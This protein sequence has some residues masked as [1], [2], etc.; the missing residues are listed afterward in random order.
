VL[1]V[2]DEAGCTAVDLVGLGA[3][4]PGLRRTLLLPFDDLTPVCASAR[5]RRLRLSRAPGAL[6]LL[7]AGAIPWPA[8]AAVVTAAIDVLPHQLSAAIAFRTGA[9]RRLLVADAPG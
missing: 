4:A 2:E 5:P 7:I 9:A 3:E 6:A 8:P 1:G